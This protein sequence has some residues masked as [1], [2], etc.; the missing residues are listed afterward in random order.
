MA[1]FEYDVF[2]SYSRADNK[3]GWVSG[4]RD[5]IYEDF[6]EF[7]SE[8]FRIF[9]DTTEIASRQDWELGPRQGLVT[10]RVL[11]V[12]L[13]PNY[14]RSFY[15]RW[16]WEEFA[17]VQAHRI[18]GGDAVT[19]VYFVELGAADQYEAVIAPWRQQIE[20]AQFEQL[21]PW[22][23]N[24]VAALQKAEV[25]ERIKA[26]GQDVHKQLRQAQ[27]AN[28]GPGNLRRHNPWFVGRADELRALRHELTRS[29]VR[30]VTAV[31]GI[32]GV[33]K[34]EL[35]VTY[36]HAYAHTYQ[37]GTWQVDADGQTDMLEAISALALSPEL[38]LAVGEQYLQDRRRLG[39]RVLARLGEFTAAARTQDA[40]TAA[41][42]LLLDNVSKP[43]LLAESQLA[44]LPE[45]SWFH[46]AVTTRLGVGDVGATGSRASLTMIEVGRLGGADA[47][48]LIREHQPARDPARLHPEFS[49]PAEEDA[50]RLIVELL[51]GYA[52]AVEQAAVYLGSS[53]VQP[54]QLLGLLRAQGAAVLDEVGA[55]PEGA[56]AILHKEK[57]TAAIVD[58]TL[59]R[60]PQRARDALALA[61]LLPPDTIAWLWLQQL[62]DTAGGPPH[63]GLPGLLGGDDWASTRRVLEGRRLLTLA[64]DTRFARLHRVLC[65][66]LRHRLA[67]RPI[68]Q[69]L[70]AHLGRVSDE[71]R[72]AAT[73]D[74]ALLAVTATTI[75]S[76]LADGSHDVAAAG[77]WLI[78]PVQSHLDLVTAHTLATATLTTYQRLAEADPHDTDW[79]RS[80]WVSLTRVGNVLAARGD[81]AGALDHYTQAL[82]VRERLAE[83]DPHD[84]D[85][86]RNLSIGLERVD[87]VLAGRGEATGALEHHTR[88]LRIRE[89]L[90][91]ADPHNTD[92]Q[93]NLLSSLERV[94]DV[95]AGRGDATGALEHHT[96]ALRIRE[97][98]AEAD[99]HD[100][101]WQRE[102]S[103][104]LERVGDVLAGRGEAGGALEHYTR[105]LRIRERLA[106]A[107][108]R[109]TGWQRELSVSLTR[110]GDVLAGRGEA[111]G[112]LQHHTR[113][114]RIAERLTEADPRNTDRQ[115]N[116]CVSLTRVGDVLAGRGE[117]AGARQHHTRALRIA[118]RLTEADPHNTDRQR[119]LSV[120]LDRV[121]DVLAE[122]GEAAGALQHYTRSLRIAERLTEADPHNTDRQRGL[123]VS[124]YKIASVQEASGAPTPVDHWAKAH[125]ILAALDAAGKLSDSDRQFL[126][127]VSGK[128]GSE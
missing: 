124:L 38:G 39:R 6:R 5:A 43:Q 89:R 82:H 41:C 42:L 101:G 106:E 110:V 71:L 96:R 97:R 48:E 3:D 36:A 21:Q 55:S 75:A 111:A 84:T 10:S 64:Y 113:A 49:G 83:A 70:D 95:L 81:A 24:G 26:L 67:D 30:V 32:G 121:G 37:G 127:Y 40:G 87:D 91:E 102:L 76:R 31:Q 16:E 107:D 114:L 11:L 66:H 15:C 65:E 23:P 45:Q 79:Q 115:R 54:T 74:T 112:A 28:A 80:L 47:L 8:P 117:A 105:A 104:R 68:Q 103:I 125:H 86:Q 18:G 78:D 56:R 93:R 50:A 90:A 72:A 108:P 53:G 14:L 61:A 35:A 88:A 1:P 62:T 73:P 60:L 46:L 120:S 99:P 2:I 29:K 17:W 100:T 7:S 57:I 63:N 13:S 123:W 34:T 59:E 52:L 109:N 51:D 44:L 118:E 119:E 98:L 19:G 77:L 4:L 94:G 33:G 25:R 22:F 116:L 12:C 92:W 85:W 128:L 122:R 20:R 9:F 27:L 126:H 69:R 58:Q